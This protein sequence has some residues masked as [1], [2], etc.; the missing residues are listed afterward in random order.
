MLKNL[1]NLLNYSD[2][3]KAL[4]NRDLK[5]RYKKS[6]LGYIWTWLDPLLTMF[7]FIFVFGILLN[8]RTENFPVYLIT[9]LVPWIFFSQTIIGSVEIITN[10]AELIKRVFFPR[11]IFPLTLSFSNAINM[12][13]SLI[14]VLV[15]VFLYQLPLTL[16]FILL[17]VHIIFLL[18]FSLGIGFFLSYLNVF[19]RDLSHIIP[20]IIRLWFFLTPVFYVVDKR[21]PEKY[22]SVYWILNPPAVFLSLFRSAL[23]GK[24]LPD[25]KYVFVCYLTA[26]LIFTFGYTFF[27][28][29]ESRMVKRI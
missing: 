6:I 13:F 18:L 4:V 12:L 15:L 7:V 28:K 23:M 14:V 24:D 16:Q 1:L 9:G 25:L 3:I 27:K 19:F 8:I 22:L 10:N 26:T 5:A 11:E 17:P 21:I 2:L 29:N 20:F